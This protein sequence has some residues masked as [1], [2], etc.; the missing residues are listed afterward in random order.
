MKKKT[1]NAIYKLFKEFAQKSLKDFDVEIIKKAY[2]FHRLFFDDKSLIAFKQ[3]R[4]IVTKMGM[5]LYPALAELIA[6]EKYAKVTREKL[7]EG[8]VPEDTSSTIDRIVT[9]LRGKQRVP[10]H[11]SELA[12][13]EKTFTKKS[14][15]KFKLIRTIAD[16][17]IEDFSGG[18][19]FAEI[20]TPLPNLDICAETKKKILTFKTI[21]QGKN[22]KAFLAFPYNPFITRANYKHLTKEVMDMEAEVLM[23]E[24]FWNYIGG[25]GTFDNLLNIIEIVGDEIRAGKS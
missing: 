7:I 12:E 3:E 10:N 22:P 14:A 20:K 13:I 15:G 21:M 11:E 2:P 5:Q 6:S 4:S 25:K 9:E 24:E 19:F 18:P 17:Y 8:N 16:I 1:T 23:A